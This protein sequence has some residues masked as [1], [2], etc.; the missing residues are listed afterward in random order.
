MCLF[1]VSISNICRQI[2]I[3]TSHLY[4]SLKVLFFF[5]SEKRSVPL[6]LPPEK[7]TLNS[8]VDMGAQS[9]SK[10]QQ[11]THMTIATCTNRYVHISIWSS[12]W[13]GPA[14][15]TLSSIQ[16]LS[17]FKECLGWASL[18]CIVC[19]REF[20]PS[21]PGLGPHQ[22]TKHRRGWLL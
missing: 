11:N 19:G 10:Q 12:S 9:K 22:H 13:H 18:T 7:N 3:L 6:T 21:E 1:V 17:I 20:R 8:G 16:H 2:S 4:F 5:H 15:L 14:A